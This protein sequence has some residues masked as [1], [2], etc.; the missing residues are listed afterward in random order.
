MG[1]FNKPNYERRVGQIKID[2][3]Y[4]V[5]T[6]LAKFRILNVKYYKATTNLLCLQKK[7]ISFIMTLISVIFCLT[8]V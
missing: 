6:K 8:D 7:H 5:L 1:V 3:E 2:K 4:I